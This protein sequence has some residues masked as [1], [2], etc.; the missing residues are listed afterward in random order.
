[1]GVDGP[2]PPLS[3]SQ[4][5]VAGHCHGKGTELSRYYPVNCRCASATAYHPAGEQVMRGVQ[6]GQPPLLEANEDHL[7]SFGSIQVGWWTPS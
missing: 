6:H 5:A 2:W 4:A 3:P 1:M 7:G